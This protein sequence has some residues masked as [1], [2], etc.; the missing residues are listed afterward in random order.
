VQPRPGGGHV[1]YHRGSRQILP[2]RQVASDLLF[3][4][5]FSR[6]QARHQVDFLVEAVG[7][8]AEVAD[9]EAACAGWLMPLGREGLTS[10][11]DPQRLAQGVDIRGMGVGCRSAEDHLIGRVVPGTDLAAVHREALGVGYRDQAE[12]TDEPGAVEFVEIAWLDVPVGDAEVPLQPGQR[13]RDRRDRRHH[14]RQGPACQRLGD[15]RGD[16]HRQPRR[17][18]LAGL[19]R[20]VG[21]EQREQPRHPRVIAEEP[22]LPHEPLIGLA[23]DLRG[24][25]DLQ[26][27]YCPA[28]QPGCPIDIGVPAVP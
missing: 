17:V 7:P 12:I 8:R 19:V 13:V 26:G 22:D 28:A 2:L 3:R 20:H 25:D 4:R 21:V 10:R 6:M 5:P 14:V 15:G 23:F 11:E 24:V 1:E 27:H 9:P 18:R 16:R